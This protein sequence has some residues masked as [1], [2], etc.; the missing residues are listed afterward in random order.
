MARIACNF[1]ITFDTVGNIVDNAPFPHSLVPLTSVN[2]WLHFIFGLSQ[3]AICS[4]CTPQM[5]L[6]DI[7]DVLINSQ[8]R[9]IDM[10][11]FLRIVHLIWF[12]SIFFFF[13]FAI[14]FTFAICSLFLYLTFAL[15]LFVKR[16]RLFLFVET[17]AC[18]CSEIKFDLQRRKIRAFTLKPW[19]ISAKI[20][21]K[22][23]KFCA[24]SNAEALIKR[25]TFHLLVWHL[26]HQ[27][28]KKIHNAD[29]FVFVWVFFI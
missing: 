12:S 28:K 21:G 14:S 19:I 18:P 29:Q 22:N 5:S 24:S 3:H 10:D 11:L 16:E 2:V 26:C 27:N 7:D 20:K 17:K 23:K 13:R 6:H 8:P 15:F 4:I 9:L 25:V 1:Q